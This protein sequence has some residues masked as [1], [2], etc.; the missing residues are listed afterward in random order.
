MYCA[1]YFQH[2]RVFFLQY[3]YLF[4]EVFFHRTHC[5]PYFV[6]LS[7]SLQ[8]LKISEFSETSSNW[9]S[10]DAIP[11][12]S[13][14]LEELCILVVCLFFYMSYV[15]V[16]VFMHL[17][18]F[19]CLFYFLINYIPSVKSICSVQMGLGWAYNWEDNSSV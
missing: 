11:L 16:L 1:F 13:Y 12:R 19:C 17:V 9:L 8:I 15:T 5:I 7:V 4:D 6:Q 3:F 2:F 14:F 18:L 10:L